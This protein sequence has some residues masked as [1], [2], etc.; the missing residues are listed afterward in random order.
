MKKGKSELGKKGE[1]IAKKYLADKGYEILATNLKV[2]FGE[3]DIIAIDGETLVIVEVKTKSSLELGLPQEMVNA[4]KQ[5]KLRKIASAISKNYG[6][7]D[8]RIDVIGI[9][10]GKNRPKIEHIADA[11]EGLQ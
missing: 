2:P 6:Y 8:F 3:A 9:L 1:K 11:V 10:I 5:K 7:E 4:T